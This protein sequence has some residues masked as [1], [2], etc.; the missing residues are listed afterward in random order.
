LAPTSFPRPPAP[1]VG[2]NFLAGTK[3][4]GPD[5]VSHPR[6]QNCNSPIRWS[7]ENPT[8]AGR[9][10]PRCSL[11]LSHKHEV[12][13]IIAADTALDA[14]AHTLARCRVRLGPP[15][16]ALPPN[17]K[18]EYSWLLSSIFNFQMSGH[19]ER[20]FDQ[21]C[22]GPQG[23]FGGIGETGALH[24]DCLGG[25]AACEEQTPPPCGWF[26]QGLDFFA[27]T[28]QRSFGLHSLFVLSIRQRMQP[29]FIPPTR[30]FLHETAKYL[31][32]VGTSFSP[33]P[34][35]VAGS[36]ISSCFAASAMAAFASTVP[37]GVVLARA[38]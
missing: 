27:V 37:R 12:C 22:P 7:G 29:R 14:A 17:A 6:S 18:L 20:G 2:V 28:E 24:G 9:A 4:H 35:S 10:Q 36:L 3:R 38:R 21:N 5:L 26:L 1:E 31:S 11:S 25:T 32:K 8:G 13:S 19:F 30:D 15:R 33:L 34:Q 23:P 16:W